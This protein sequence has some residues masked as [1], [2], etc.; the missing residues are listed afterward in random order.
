[1]NKIR[2]L[3]K[4]V[5]LALMMTIVARAE[6][7]ETKTKLDTLE[8]HLIGFNFATL[9]PTNQPSTATLPDGSTT[10]TGNLFSLYK[11]PWLNFGVNVYYKFK[12]NWLVNIEGNL[13]F[14]TDNLKNRVE[15]MSNLYSRDSIIIGENG[16]D[17]VATCYNRALNLRAGFGKIFPLCPEK[18]PNSGILATL[19]AGWMLQQTIF[20][21]NDVYAPQLADDYA[22]LYDHQ[23]QGF[24][25][26]QGIGYW[27]MSNHANLVNFYVAFEVT[28]CWSKSTRNYTIDNLIGISGKDNNKYFDLM[29]SIKL[30]WMFTLRGKTTPEYYYY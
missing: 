16:T 5:L 18:N 27:F 13:W 8:C 14:G 6:A 9:F 12:S 26:T 25:L 4:I 15:R 17:A 24:M 28:E 22:L 11:A 23:R 29:F 19:N 2:I 10:H 7:Q 20:T 1:M 3:S 21:L 30:C